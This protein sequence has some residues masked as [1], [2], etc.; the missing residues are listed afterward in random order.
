M[1]VFQFFGLLFNWALQGLLFVQACKSLSEISSTVTRSPLSDIAAQPDVYYV[2]FPE[3]PVFRKCLGEF[4][5]DMPYS[6]YVIK[7]TCSLRRLCV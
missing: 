2:C 7:P 6:A 5:I 4:H 1:S 3:D